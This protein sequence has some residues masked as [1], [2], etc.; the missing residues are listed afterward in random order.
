MLRSGE[1][2]DC[3]TYY[4]AFSVLK[5][6]D[7]TGIT[8]V[9]LCL[10]GEGR[11]ILRLYKLDPHATSSLVREVVY[12]LSSGEI[13]FFKT[14][15]DRSAVIIGVEIEAVDEFVHVKAGEW[16]TLSEP[17]REVCLAGVITSFRREEE[18]LAAIE[19]FAEK[20]IPGADGKFGRLF[21]IDNGQTLPKMAL[22][23][24][25]ILQ[26]ANLGGA[27]GFTRG[28]LEARKAGCF[29]HVLFMD[30]DASCEPSSV[31]RAIALLS[32]ALDE[33]TAVSGSMLFNDRPTVQHEKT[34]LFSKFEKHTIPLRPQGNNFDL[35]R[36]VDLVRN[37]LLVEG[38]YGAWW[39]FAFPLNCVKHLPFPFFVR[40]DDIDFSLANAFKIVSLNGIASRSEDFGKKINCATEYLSAR[41]LLALAFLHGNMERIRRTFVQLV[42]VASEQGRAFDYARMEAGLAGLEDVMKGIQHFR[43]N[44][45]AIET[46]RALGANDT[47]RIMLQEDMMRLRTPKKAKGIRRV[48]NVLTCWG[49]LVPD[50]LSKNTILNHSDRGNLAKTDVGLCRYVA[51]E[52]GGY[53]L[54]LERDKKRFFE[55]RR[56]IRRLRRHFRKQLEVVERDYKNNHAKVRS[57]EFWER[58][59]ADVC[60]GNHPRPSE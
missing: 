21:V 33:S 4:N 58:A 37:E 55:G 6:L 30:D 3:I 54:L 11:V 26:N 35:S 40:G 8:D 22:P 42:K 56:R 20:V 48:K 16:N 44:P 51:F 19:K 15:A 31:W 46:I 24:V 12:D 7:I 27:G 5:W 59:L 52:Q 2:L 60:D 1:C 9:G 39:Y 14:P 18:T 38:N 10:H 57:Q 49:H 17:Q 23:G 50:W 36:R 13:V 28:L 25:T 29:T 34:A 53:G 43:D 32:N 47:K 45:S 41:S